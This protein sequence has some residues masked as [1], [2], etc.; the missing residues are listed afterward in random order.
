MTWDRVIR[1]VIGSAVAFGGTAI[2][3]APTTFR[4]TSPDLPAGKSFLERY[5]ANEFGCHGG[6]QSPALKWSGAPA[7]TKSF[8][9]TMYDPYKP[10]QSGW[11]H[12]IVYDLPATT[13]ELPRQAGAAG[14]AGLPSGAKQG[15]PDG[16]AP[17]P[18]Y[19]GPC[20]DQG[21]P[22]HRYLITVY[23]LSVDR[24]DV[25]ST[26]TA[27]DLDYVIAGKMIGKASIARAYQRPSTVE[28]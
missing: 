28:K 9:V 24:L 26:A 16:D 5:V 10:P 25:P 15:L 6:N 27:A 11:W 4:L 1:W 8:A 3:A 23:A 13:L 2:A 18:H 17:Q 19:Y 22:P 12:W 21:D 20:P 7:G 14:G